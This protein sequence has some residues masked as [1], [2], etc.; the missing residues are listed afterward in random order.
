MAT[1]WISGIFKGMSD[2]ANDQTTG[3]PAAGKP[4]PKRKPKRTPANKAY[5]PPENKATHD[6]AKE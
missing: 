1:V 5:E 2:H 3:E 4:K 6:E